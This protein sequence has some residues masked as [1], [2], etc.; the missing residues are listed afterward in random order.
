MAARRARN[1]GRGARHP[2]RASKQ[3][4]TPSK[5]LK[6][7]HN[8]LRRKAGGSSIYHKAGAW[9]DR[10]DVLGVNAVKICPVL[11]LASAIAA[12][13]CAGPAH[14]PP[15]Q[16]LRPL[17][18]AATEA[19]APPE[20][21]HASVWAVDGVTIMTAHGQIHASGHIVMQGGRIVE[22]G[23]GPLVAPAHAHVVDGRGHFITPGI[24]DLHS[25]LGVFAIPFVPAI[26]EVNEDVQP[27][28]ADVWAEHGFW[29][30][31]PGLRRAVSD[32]G[33]TTVQVLPG[34]A[35]L[36]GG[37]SFIA[38][39]K[40][41]TTARMMRFP[42][43]LPGLK[44][45]CGE[46]PK[47]VYGERNTAPKT[48]MG[49]M[50]GMRRAFLRAHQYRRSWDLHAHELA[51]WRQGHAQA[52]ED[53]PDAPQPPERDLALETLAEVLDGKRAVHAHCYRADDMANMLDLAY[54]FNFRIRAFHH[55][56]EAY[57]IADRLAE[58]GVGVATWA[59]WWGFKMESFDG[60][61]EN[62]GMLTEAGVT[63]AL[64]SD[65]EIEIR[66][67]HQEAAKAQTASRRAGIAI[68]D[69]TALRWLTA[70]PARLLGIDKQTGTLEAGKMADVVL[71]DHHPFSIY[72]RP[73]MV[74]IDGEVVFDRKDGPWVPSD[75]ELGRP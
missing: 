55:A 53:D 71:W 7:R 32:G 52:G 10:S 39:L 18:T 57:K 69:D 50:A 48:R 6:E 1:V 44:M 31:D 20:P 3:H 9:L 2:A 47:R 24:I 19:P 49:N 21:T 51:Q 62:V 66:S 73:A 45:A 68:D 14:G 26:D 38:K 67:L 37:R 46:N 12:C 16:A 29:P 33:I 17:P 27:V 5:P 43:A 64:H 70:N 61:R 72:A 54:A 25:H 41:H 4:P 65:S 30:Q 13:G 36:I 59:N 35:N 42:D 8:A 23:E 34:S 11:I 28:T 75:F 22:I 56:V 60:I 58:A 15:S 40:P 74:W 63:T